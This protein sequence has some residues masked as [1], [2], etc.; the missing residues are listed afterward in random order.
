VGGPERTSIGSGSGGG[1]LFGGIRRFWIDCEKQKGVVI[2]R[3][4]EESEKNEK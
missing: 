2:S 4:N 1:A 3:K